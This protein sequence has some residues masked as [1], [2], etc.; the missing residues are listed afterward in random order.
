MRQY[1]NH[2]WP[3]FNG[4][5]SMAILLTTALVLTGCRTTRKVVEPT[6]E[7]PNAAVVFDAVTRVNQN[8]IEAKA[9]KAKMNLKATAGHSNVS[10]GGSIKMK[11]DELIQ[12]SIMFMGFVEAGRMEL[13]PDYLYVQNRVSHEYVKTR[14]KDIKPLHDAGIDFYAFQAL[15]WEELFVPGKHSE[16]KPKEFELAD[17]GT[18]QKLSPTSNAKGGSTVAVDFIIGTVGGLIRQTH[19]QPESDNSLSFDWNYTRWT[20]LERKD[21][22]EQMQVKV[23]SGKKTYELGLGLS[24]VEALTDA[25][26]LVPTT[27]SKRYKEVSLE[28]IINRLLNN[29]R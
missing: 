29:G 25:S 4:Q 8:R 26:D 24:H 22:P 27:P 12:I 10:A 19:I 6:E 14:W 18:T 20:A 28:T 21:F 5:W 7:A 3:I 9:I 1:F 15:F 16:P 13:T 11:R 17:L 23:Q 2:Q